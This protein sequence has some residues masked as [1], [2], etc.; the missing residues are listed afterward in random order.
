MIVEIINGQIWNVPLADLY[1]F[2]LQR[3]IATFE[4]A[5]AWGKSHPDQGFQVFRHPEPNQNPNGTNQVSALP[6]VPDPTGQAYTLENNCLIVN[7]YKVLYD[8]KI[9]ALRHTH[10]K[11]G[12][13]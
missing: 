6:L 3:T 1:S 4:D 7:D 11:Q 5:L 12:G 10:L 13:G 9:G 2:G 8:P